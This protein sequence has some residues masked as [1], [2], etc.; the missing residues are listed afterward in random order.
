VTVYDQALPSQADP[1]EAAL[2]MLLQR[3]SIQGDRGDSTQM[4]TDTLGRVDMGRAGRVRDMW[5]ARQGADESAGG[6]YYSA[7]QAAAGGSGSGGGSGTAAGPAP[8]PTRPNYQFP[9]LAPPVAAQPVR[10]G[11][12]PVRRGGNPFKRW[13]E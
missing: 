10:S 2:A 7:L 6:A 11:R 9:G 8:V 12:T 13:V 4:M 1:R 3:A 5:V